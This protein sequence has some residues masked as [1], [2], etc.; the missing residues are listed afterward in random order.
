MAEPCV[1]GHS[2]QLMERNEFFY[3]YFSQFFISVWR[4]GAGR[5]EA[6]LGD[7]IPAAWSRWKL[8]RESWLALGN[9][10]CLVSSPLLHGGD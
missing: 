2:G 8:T 4:G 9:G 3:F 1:T 10:S 7:I 6:R 5:G